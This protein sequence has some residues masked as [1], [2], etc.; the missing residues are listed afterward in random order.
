MAAPAEVFPGFVLL[1]E[2]GY[3]TTGVVYDARDTRLNRRVALKAPFLVPEGERTNRTERFLRECQVLAHL[4][5][6]PPVAI[7]GIL[8]VT[9]FQGQPFYIRELVDGDSLEQRAAIGS[10]DL[11]DGLAVISGVARVVQ[12]VHEQGFVHRNLSATN[13][14]VARNNT[15]R[16]IGF[17]RV[18]LLAGS[19]HVQAGAGTPAE[20]DVQGLRDLLR[21]LCDALR[22]AVP[23]D[24]ECA[25]Q[26][27]SVASAGAFAEAV[28]SHLRG[29]QA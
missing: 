16:L 24:V 12:W 26:P 13:V 8:A 19:D 5:S 21:W 11:R 28:A 1:G 14:L 27:G 2:L 20:V 6:K 18:G 4:T 15:A 3:G 22:R 23:A 9:E 29:G 10:I 17:G 7:P 25:I